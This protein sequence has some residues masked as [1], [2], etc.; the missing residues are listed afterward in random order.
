MIRLVSLPA[1]PVCGID[2]STFV[3][4]E[5]ASRSDHAFKF[6]PGP[7]VDADAA[8]MDADDQQIDSSPVRF[9]HASSFLAE[10]PCSALM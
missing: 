10:H 2:N 7:V 1:H 5:F 8:D 6:T 9:V 3:Q 4:I